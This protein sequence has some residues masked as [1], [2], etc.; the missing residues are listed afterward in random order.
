MPAP[1]PLSLSAL[2]VVSYLFMKCTL[3]L[4]QAQTTLPWL[5]L[6]AVAVIYVVLGMPYESWIHPATILLGIPSAAVGALLALKIT[7]PELTFIAMIGVLLIGVV[8][9]SFSPKRKTP[10]SVK[11]DGVRNFGGVDGTRT[12]DPRRDRPVF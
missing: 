11:L 6:I 2:L 3:R 4:R 12:R 1:T 10:S 7:E 5:A 8:T 9:R